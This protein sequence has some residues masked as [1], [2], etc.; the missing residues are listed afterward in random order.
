MSHEARAH[1]KLSPSKAA[2]W[3]ACPPSVHFA[4]SVEGSVRPEGPK[5]YAKEGT[6]AH[7]VAEAFLL[8]ER[9]PSWADDDMLRH[10]EG[11]RDYCHALRDSV[12]GAIEAVEMRVDYSAYVPGGTGLCDYLCVAGDT[13]HVVDYKYGRSPVS[14]IGNP[15]IRLYALGA[16][17]AFKGARDI[18]F[19]ECHVYQPRTPGPP[20]SAER[21]G[22]DELL[23]WTR[24][25]VAPAAALADAGQGDKK[26]GDH[27]KW[28][29]A[30]P[31]CPAWAEEVHKRARS[32]FPDVTTVTDAELADVYALS[33]SLRQYLDEVGEH[34]KWRLS[35]GRHVPGVKL[36]KR[37]GRRKWSDVEAVTAA[38]REAG[39]DDLITE[40]P[41][42][43]VAAEKVLGKEKVGSLTQKSEDSVT[44]ALDEDGRPAERGM[45]S[46]LS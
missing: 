20:A 2:R 46:P 21:I 33:S 4:E 43:V 9:P 30:L 40:K 37:A 34:L 19:V 13:I 41:C 31:V 25:V 10:G 28:C 39:R 29:R 11:Y 14:A 24:N 22:V 16:Y 1:A 12:R 45:F 35:A 17:E 42:G 44:L 8:S 15:Q 38:L 23:A 27:C 6:R 3:I 18:R 5:P 7:E 26:A 32:I 36:V